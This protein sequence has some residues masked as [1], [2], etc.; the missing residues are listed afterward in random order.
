MALLLNLI[1]LAGSYGP[2]E[3]ATIHSYSFNSTT[4]HLSLN[5][6][7]RGISNA[8]YLA[9]CDDGASVLAVSE[10]NTDSDA[11]TLLRD[12]GQGCYEPVGTVLTEGKSPCHI[13]V[14]PDG[15]YA[16][17]ANYGGGSI[18]IIP[19]SSSDGTIDPATVIRFEG[20][21]ADSVRQAS[22]HAHF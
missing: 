18:S 19:F 12:S 16:V 15:T 22:P 21:G 13:A 6:E 10:N 17:T 5:G 14:S 3:E 1:L 20:H 9:L 4:G 8:S 7:V 2:A 11:V